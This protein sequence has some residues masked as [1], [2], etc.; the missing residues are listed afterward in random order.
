MFTGTMNRR[1]EA[2]RT[3]DFLYITKPF[4]SRHMTDLIKKKYWLVPFIIV[5]GLASYSW[6]FSTRAVDYNA[7]VKPILN[8]KCIS[9]HGGVRRKGGFSIMFREDAVAPTESGKPA[10][11]P[12]DPDRSE[13]IRRLTS[14]S[15]EDRMPYHDKPLA[16]EEINILRQWI[17]EGANFGTH[18]AYA[19]IREVAPPKPKGALWGLLP[20]GK[21]DFVRNDVDYFILDKLHAE[22]LTPSGE[23]DKR[24]LIRRVSLDLTGLPA[25]R[26]IADRY[27]ADNSDKAY[28]DLVDS[29]LALPT[30]GERWT[31][32][33]LDL[34]RYADTK[35]YERDDS[36][37]IWRYRDW[38]IKSFNQDM[39]YDRFLTEQL[40]GDLLPSPSDEQLIATAF[41]RNTMTNDE[42][43]TDNEE[44]RTAAVMDR[45]NTTWQALM[46]TSFTCAQCHGHPYDPF[47]QDDYYKFLAF[48]NNSRDEDSWSEYPLLKE[49]HGQDS[50]KFLGLKEWLD[51]NAKADAAR[52]ILHFVKTGQPA[53]NSLLADSFANA[54]LADTKWLIMRK[55]SA[56]RLKQV[57]LTDRNHLLFRAQTYTPDGHLVVRLDSAHGRELLR[58]SLP[59]TK[60]Q[61][62]LF[63]VSLPEVKDKHDLH[64][65]YASSSLTLQTQNGI[66][67]DWFRFTSEFPGQ[68]GPDRDSAYRHYL[69][70]VSSDKV[71]S[72]P[73]MLD[74]PEDMY[75]PTRIFVKGNWLVKGDEVRAAVP[76]S[77]NPMPKGAPANRLGLSQWMT[78]PENPLVSRTL[79]NRLW[80]QLFGTGLAETLEDLGTQGTPPTHRELIDHL[81]YRFM[82]E[83]KWSMKNLLREMVM[84]ATYRQDSRVTPEGSQKDPYNRYYARGPRVRLD[85]EELRDQ[86]LAVSGLLSPGMYGPSVMPWQPAGIWLSPW[87]GQSWKQSDGAEQYRRS[88]YTY[89]KRTSPF[90]AM[91]M[92]DGSA[93]EVCLARRIR[94]NTPLQ[95]LTLLNDSSILVASRQLA[96]HMAGSGTEV[97][98]EIG[99]GY[100]AIMGRSADMRK[101]E[102]LEK[103]YRTALDKYKKDPEAACAMNG[104]QLPGDASGRAALVVVA[105]ALLNMDEFIT[106]N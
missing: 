47:K 100:E 14:H 81:S 38:L 44:F 96:E 73:I 2:F 15:P 1:I 29:L 7:Q 9:C 36:R 5:V 32:M 75:R 72:T 79:V 89:W 16:E 68:A 74:N 4:L 19:P 60:G 40:A 99:K 54:E 39:P 28:P 77:L 84:S 55:N 20:A 90:P 63:N 51:R 102:A 46:G 101:V 104:L 83:M 27:L 37:S 62:Q 97:R 33:W 17:R 86:A 87:N 35:G 43:G 69:D 41:H 92:F 66:M 8:K 23:A 11:I 6:I 18:W 58:F 48:F 67:F 94:T 57:A 91:I 24:I 106:K 13:F 49:F 65:E 70:L 3:P 61:W 10:I 95:A 64:I 42:G 76:N 34:A 25:P 78:S 30:Y 22:G 59:E 82:H 12:G 45:V 26:S 21:P 53:I 80:E 98:A 103:L 56:A 50:L 31:G 85:A 93:R 88:V 71:T 105:G 52:D